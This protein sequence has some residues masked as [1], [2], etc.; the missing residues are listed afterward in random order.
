MAQGG[1][2]SEQVFAVRPH[3]PFSSDFNCYHQLPRSRVEEHRVSGRKHRS[4]A[5]RICICIANY[6]QG[7]WLQRA[8][9]SIL[10]STIADAVEIV[11]VDS[12]STRDGVAAARERFPQPRY[13]EMGRN[14]GYSTALNR[15]LAETDA[16]IVVCANADIEFSPGTL[17]LLRDVLLSH[18]NAAGAAPRFVF[19]DGAAQPSV[20]AF[21]SLWQVLRMALVPGTRTRPAPEMG[22][23]VPVE[24]SVGACVMYRRECLEE[25]AGFDERFFLYYEEVDLHRRLRGA[26]YGLVVAPEAVVV[27]HGGRATGGATA[28]TVRQHLASLFYYL[29][30]HDGRGQELLG[31]TILAIGYLARLAVSIA[32]LPVMLVVALARR[33][34]PLGALAKYAS[35]LSCCVRGWTE[36]ERGVEPR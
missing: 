7:E 1:C 8:I 31:R 13:I 35:L 14:C 34:N 25:V 6:N 30:K 24:T 32:L 9:D 26:G 28:T 19:G 23:P 5:E 10:R 11:V 4:V 12:G 16:P 36:T 18:G 33:A 27:H 2:L 20:E 15:G 22:G 17:E 3:K 29:R 21:P